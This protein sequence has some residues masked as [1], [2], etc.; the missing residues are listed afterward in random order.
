MMDN[1]DCALFIWIRLFLNYWYNFSVNG[2]FRCPEKLSGMS[3]LL[4]TELTDL[5]C[6][7][8]LLCFQSTF[9]LDVVLDHLE[10]YTRY[11]VQVSAGNYYTATHKL[12]SVLGPP[13][14]FSTKTGSKWNSFHHFLLREN[15]KCPVDYIRKYYF[16]SNTVWNKSTSTRE[17]FIPAAN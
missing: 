4:V 12:S 16:A 17:A 13:L 9:D 2:M 14:Y 7:S 6:L 11:L 8:L 10:P 1:A 5:Y 15:G 3:D